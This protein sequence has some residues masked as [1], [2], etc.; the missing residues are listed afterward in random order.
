MTLAMYARGPVEAYMTRF[1][2]LENFHR[3]TAGNDNPLQMQA[4]DLLSAPA[5]HSLSNHSDNGGSRHDSGARS[6]DAV[7]SGDDVRPGGSAR[8]GDT[9]G[10][11]A[12]RLVPLDLDERGAHTIKSG[13]SLSVIAF[14]EL[15]RRGESVNGSSLRTEMQRIVDINR[16]KFPSLKDHPG[17]IR[18]GWKLQV[19]DET[20]GPEPSVKWKPW[21]TAESGKMTVVKKGER[22]IAP[23]GAWLIVEPGAQAILNPGSKAFL[24]ENAKIVKASPGALVLAVGGTVNDYGAQIQMVGDNVRINRG[25]G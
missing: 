8:P 16:E 9:A 17:R 13:E 23:D 14:R 3:A 7:R 11:A 25:S 6:G 15:R 1:D 4:G 22:M 10:S 18:S 24:N 19:W 20:L 21:C 2:S 5:R 12:A